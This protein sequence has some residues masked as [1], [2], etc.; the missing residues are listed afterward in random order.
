MGI[1]IGS[2][3]FSIGF[4]EVGAKTNQSTIHIVYSPTCPHCHSLFS[5]LENKTGNLYVDKTTSG[6]R[7]YKTLSKY[8]IAW[9]GGVPLVYAEFNNTLIAV[10]GF[11]TEGRYTKSEEYEREICSNSGGDFSKFCTFSNGLILG[12]ADAVDYLLTF[13][14]QNKCE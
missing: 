13:C 10:S 3:I 6:G 2:L 12:N 11:P 8:E 14:T 7:A 4:K 1:L 9:S 5:Y